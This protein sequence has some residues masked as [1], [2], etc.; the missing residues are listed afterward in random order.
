VVAATHN[1]EAVLSIPAYVSA[2]ERL[3]ADEAGRWLR[4]PHGRLALVLHLSRLKDPAP[5]PHQSRIAHALLQDMALR[6]GGQVFPMRNGDLVL[7]CSGEDAAAAPSSQQAMP[8]ALPA[9]L[10][11]LFGADAP[12]DAPLTSC[13]KLEG[14]A[15]AL[16]QYIG[17]RLRDPT[18]PGVA[19]APPSEHE[20]P[21]DAIESAIDTLPFERAL[22]QQTAIRVLPGRGLP[23][24]GRLAPLFREVSFSLA[25]I[26]TQAGMA[27]AVADPFLLRHFATRLDARLLA[28]LL[29][30]LT[31]T[32][33]LTRPALLGRL[34]L[35]VNLTLS[36]IVSPAF[37]QL[38]HAA[39]RHSAR[40]GIEIALLEAVGDPVQ[41]ALATHALNAAGFGLVLDGVNHL[42]LA[43]TNPAVLKPQWLKLAW[44]PRLADATSEAL[45]PV[46]A[47]I[48]RI[49]AD[50]I[51]MRQAD[52]EQALAWGLARGVT[53][54]QGRFPDAVQAARRIAVCHSARHCSLR[55]CI[56][57]ASTADPTIR[58][59]CGN[60]AL[61]DMG[62][63]A[64]TA[65]V[66]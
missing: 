33:T 21:L 12:G 54:Y 6:Q 3:L 56:M 62:T 23:L 9:A 2:S 64:T 59:G 41:F 5:P 37:A 18:Q 46:D 53:A 47:A 50:R 19:V 35:H 39:R 27:H 38:A 42:A 17:Q 66:A 1:A 14:E 13:W 57:R 16:Q 58:T 48:E 55:Q 60:P 10:A 7:I 26:A 65:S 49:G 52:S 20:V 51:V 44:S 63:D 4:A 45:R 24:A 11:R 29:G 8:R 43:M 36:G 22:Q 28:H 15:A 61:L 31:A 34:P 40:F 30:D 32:R 25:P